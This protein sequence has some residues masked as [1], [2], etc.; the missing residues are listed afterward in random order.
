MKKNLKKIITIIL[1]FTIYA[2]IL[3]ISNIPNNMV[4]FEGETLNINTLLG[5]KINVKDSESIQ[6][7]ATESNKIDTAGKTTA[8]VS[9][10]NNILIKNVD[11]DVL[12][13][14]KVIPV[15][16]MAGLKLYTN[17][18]LVV[19]MSEIEGN[20]SKKYKPYENTGIKEGDTIIEINSDKVESTVDLIQK[21][22]NS[23]GKDINLKYIHEQETKEC[24]I[25]PV[26]VSNSQYKLGLWVRDSAAGVGTVTF[27]DTETKSFGAL[28]HGITDIDTEKLINIGSGEFV[29]TRIVNIIKGENGSPGRIQGS[30]E[31]GQNIGIISKNTKFGIYG[32][33][34]N[35]SS[36]NID[37]S[38]E[39]EV[40][41]R[42]EIKLGKASILCSL[43]NQNIESYEIEIEKIYKQNNYD[44]KSMQIK[45]TDPKLLEKTGGIIQGMSGS[46]IIQNGK[47]IGAVTH[48]LV[49]NPQEGYGV[50][51]D[52]MIKQMKNTN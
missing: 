25:T 15:G 16:S 42:D 8:E 51:G 36:L 22:N 49:N 20:D 17:G 9:L 33:V 12:P 2:Y 31:N 5:L 34:N 39:M 26:K 14:T 35:L 19:G 44:N 10:F 45:V 28:G 11:V 50:F 38:K 18:V 24:S 46:P 27:Y 37:S 23:N 1:L 6:V 52:L 32:Q 4:I 7:S 29:T 3:A 13:K 43:D 47:F 48:V 30:I 21:V 41:L 40:A